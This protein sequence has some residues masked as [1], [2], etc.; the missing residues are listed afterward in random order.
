MDMGL[1][2]NWWP[3]KLEDKLMPLGELILLCRLTKDF[4]HKKKKPSEAV[5][6]CV[7]SKDWSW[8]WYIRSVKILKFYNYIPYLI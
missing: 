8:G 7:Q 3:K 2:T 6:E 1:D 4:V 5:M